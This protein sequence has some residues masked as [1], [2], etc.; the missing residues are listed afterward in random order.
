[1]KNNLEKILWLKHN[2]LKGDMDADEFRNYYFGLIFYKYLSEKIEFELN[3]FLKDKRINF[4]N[5]Y[6]NEE[7]KKELEDY[8]VKKLG[9]FI[10]PKHLFNQ[11]IKKI[12]NKYYLFDGLDKENNIIDDLNKALKEIENSSKD[13]ESENDFINIFRDINSKSEN[14]DKNK[15]ISKVLL[16]LSEIDFNLTTNE[17]TN[18]N[19]DI[20][21]SLRETTLGDIFEY[22]ISQFAL[23]IGKLN[24][25][26]T[27]KQV[28]KLLA[29]LA[30]V[31]KKNI[32]T[33]YDPCCGSASLLLRVGKEA[34][35]SDFY[36]QELDMANYN[37]ARMNMIVN[38]VSYDN[39]DIQ[40]GNVLENPK[41]LDKKFELIVSNP[42]FSIKWSA[43]KSF[44][45]DVRFK[46]YGKLAPKSKA[47]FAFIQDM[48]Y[49]LDDN[50]TMVAIVPY[51]VLFRGANEGIIRKYLIKEKN[52]LDAVIG[53]PNNIFNGTSIYTVV[54]VFRKNRENKNNIL[55]IDASKNFEKIK[56]KSIL[57]D[58]FINKIINTYNKRDEIEDYSHIASLNEIKENDYNLNISRY[59]NN[60]KEEEL[61][62]KEIIN[63][64]KDANNEIKGID[65]KV[66]EYCIQL[67]IKKPFFIDMDK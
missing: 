24:D 41:Y 55:F 11:I 46:E 5:A 2:E 15:L 64:I 56:N 16:Y 30:T 7:Y 27:P 65:K 19:T 18:K 34:Y 44:L 42:P 63:K 48:I 62:E 17:E 39:F 47:D 14:S 22:L 61:D 49:H 13:Q 23:N 32:K 35:I 1:M 50:G 3:N 58:E 8:S 26:H 31:N 57:T 36:G 52:S 37:L 43:D 66:E 45:D 6:E 51:G 28:S 33:V 54:L 38:N 9:Y 67:N 40:Q 12:K 20:E 59:I 29:K 10:Q 4:D 60:F 25:F 53:L 21:C